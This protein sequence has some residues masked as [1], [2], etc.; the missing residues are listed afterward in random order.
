MELQLART[1][2]SIAEIH[3]T[4]D[5]F[6][7]KRS[8]SASSVFAVQLA[9]EE[10][11][12]NLVKY[13]QGGGETIQFD[14]DLVG[15]RLIIQ[16]IDHDVGCFDPALVPPMDVSTPLAL[17]NPGGLGL[18][19]I[20]SYLDDFTYDYSDRTLRITAVKNLEAQDV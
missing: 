20:R 16:L 11:F 6:C 4:I 5:G 1:F 19:L 10:F 8:I 17:R 15:D 3:S 14:V 2:D 18:H 12:T 13:N 7:R 9:V